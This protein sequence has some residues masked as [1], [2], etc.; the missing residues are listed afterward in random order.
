MT[1]HVDVLIVGA[2]ISGVSAAWHV[3]ERCPS[4]SYAILESRPRMGGTWDLFR[5]PGIR[6]DSDM[7]TLGFRFRPWSGTKSIADGPSILQLRAGDRGEVPH[8]RAHPLPPQGGQ[9]RLV[10][11]QRAMDPAHRA[12]RH[13]E[14]DDVLVPVRVHRLLRLRRGLRAQLSGARG[15]HR[16]D[17]SSAALA[18]GPRLRGQEHRRHRQRRHRGHAGAEPRQDGRWSRHDAAALAELHHLHAGRGRHRGTAQSP[19]DAAR[20]LCRHAVEERARCSRRST[21]SA[22]G[23]RGGCAGC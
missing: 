9:S 16:S 14:D 4:K 6:S 11:R 17:H 2:G 15:L 10:E 8:R 19:A 1:E 21:D 18:G 7:Y 23:F 20:R 5:Y 13:R 3:Q 22:G 12:R